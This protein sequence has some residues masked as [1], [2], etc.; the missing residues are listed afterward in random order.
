MVTPFPLVKWDAYHVTIAQYTNL[1]PTNMALS[2]LCCL[3]GYAPELEKRYGTT[4]SEYS[5]DDMFDDT[6][7][8]PG[9]LRCRATLGGTRRP[10]WICAPGTRGSSSRLQA[11]GRMFSKRLITQ[12]YKQSYGTLANELWL[13]RDVV[14]R[15][16]WSLIMDEKA[17]LQ[18]NKL[19]RL[20]FANVGRM[21]F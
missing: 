6:W 11:L 9:N 2:A 18:L 17:L 4:I 10:P 19:K 13:S 15:C 5:G 14:K 12:R 16:N 1:P 8:S 7:Q 20:F 3:P 21:L